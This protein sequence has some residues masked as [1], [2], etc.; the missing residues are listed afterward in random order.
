[1]SRHRMCIFLMN[2]GIKKENTV[3]YIFVLFNEKQQ[4]SYNVWL[5]HLMCLLSVSGRL[6]WL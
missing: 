2:H 3:V 6:L 4:R 1:M 5:S